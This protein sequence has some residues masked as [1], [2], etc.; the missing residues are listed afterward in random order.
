MQTY[1]TLLSEMSE[2]EQTTAVG[3]N[4]AYDIGRAIRFL[5]VTAV[6]NRGDISI[7]AD[8]AIADWAANSVQ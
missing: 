4:L 5:V 1:H 8:F 6:E 2:T 3:G 7:G